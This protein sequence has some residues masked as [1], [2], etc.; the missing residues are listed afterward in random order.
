MQSPSLLPHTPTLLPCAIQAPLKEQRGSKAGRQRQRY[1]ISHMYLYPSDM[2]R[3]NCG[4]TNCIRMRCLCTVWCGARQGR[5]AGS[6]CL[7]SSNYCCCCRWG[8]ALSKQNDK[9]IPDLHFIGMWRRRR[10]RWH[11]LQQQHAHSG[12]RAAKCE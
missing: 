9:V 11:N 1:A 4:K 10:R 3:I 12:I 7:G 8:P 2:K 5:E 6:Q